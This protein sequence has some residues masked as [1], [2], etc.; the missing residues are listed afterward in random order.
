MLSCKE[1][2]VLYDQEPDAVYAL[3]QTLGAAK[4]LSLHNSGSV[5]IR[6]DLNVER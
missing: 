3:F 1:F 4:I 6:R 5:E 2:Q